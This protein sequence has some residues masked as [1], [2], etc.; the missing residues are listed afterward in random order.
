MGHE[1][2]K[3][4]IK[5]Y[6]SDLFHETSILESI[7]GQIKIL[8]P[9]NVTHGQPLDQLVNHFCLMGMNPK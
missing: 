2:G 6:N 1:K 8:C 5:T 9:K 3:K 4:S 7:S